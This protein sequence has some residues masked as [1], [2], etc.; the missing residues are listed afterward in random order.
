MSQRHGKETWPLLLF[1][2]TGTF[3]VSSFFG[4]SKPPAAQAID[5]RLG[6]FNE[7]ES[8]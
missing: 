7:L 3:F 4:E 5:E 1:I 2:V 8:S 6:V